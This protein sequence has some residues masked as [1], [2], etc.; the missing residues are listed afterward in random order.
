MCAC[1]KI[2]SF[3]FGGYEN[4][5]YIC[6]RKGISISIVILSIIFIMAFAYNSLVISSLWVKQG[7]RVWLYAS[8][9]YNL[10]ITSIVPA[11]INIIME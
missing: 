9:D 7:G 6:Q 4:I 1:G 8:N 2:S 3:F 5:L 10:Q 11:E